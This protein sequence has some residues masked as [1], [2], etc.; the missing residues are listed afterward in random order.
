MPE[1]VNGVASPQDGPPRPAE[2]SDP[3]AV[4]PDRVRRSL[5]TKVEGLMVR[6]LRAGLFLTL[7]SYALFLANDVFVRHEHLP[8]WC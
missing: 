4:R 5:E 2:A 8:C 7:A 1:V 3:L 6:R